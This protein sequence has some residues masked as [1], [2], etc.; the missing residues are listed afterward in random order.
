[1]RWKIENEISDYDDRNR[2]IYRYYCCLCN[3]YDVNRISRL[4]SFRKQY[5]I[6]IKYIKLEK[7][8]GTRTEE[9]EAGNVWLKVHA[10]CRKHSK[11]I[12]C[13]V[14]WIALFAFLYL[15]FVFGFFASRILYQHAAA[16]SA[17]HTHPNVIG[18]G[19]KSQRKSKQTNDKLKL[20]KHFAYQAHDANTAYAYIY[21]WRARLYVFL[22]VYLFICTN[23]NKRHGWWLVSWR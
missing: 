7:V 21:E 11:L 2:N 12:F 13:Y 14:H 10:Y 15:H 23:V 3:K 20:G 6:Y 9:R 17:Y 19:P 4:R 18:V 22:F 5:T 16:H 1:M 8:L